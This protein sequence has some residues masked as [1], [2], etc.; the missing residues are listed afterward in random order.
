MDTISAYSK[1]EDNNLKEYIEYVNKIPTLKLKEE[2][3]PFEKYKN[4]DIEARNT[5]INSYLKKVV[6]I[7]KKYDNSRIPLLELIQEGNKTLIDKVN[8]YNFDNT[9]RFYFTFFR[10]VDNSIKY[11]IINNRDI[12]IPYVIALNIVN[13]K[14]IEKELKQ[15]MGRE[16]SFDEINEKLNIDDKTFSIVKNYRNGFKS[17]EEITKDEEYDENKDS[18]I[19]VIEDEEFL[20][21]LFEFL[22][23]QDSYKNILK[24][25][26]MRNG[27]D[28]DKR[29]T[30]REIGNLLNI[31]GQWVN[32]E[33]LKVYKKI[34]EL[35]DK[36]EMNFKIPEK[37]IIEKVPK[38]RKKRE[39]KVNIK[40]KITESQNKMISKFNKSDIYE[41]YNSID[42]EYKYLIENVFLSEETPSINYLTD[43][44]KEIFFAVIYP[45]LKRMISQKEKAKKIKQSDELLEI[46]YYK[47]LNRIKREIEDED[48][49]LTLDFSFK[50]I[51]Y[52][53]E[54]IDLQYKYMLK[55]IYNKSLLAPSISWM[56]EKEREIFKSIVHP[57]MK[58]IIK[59]SKFRRKSKLCKYEENEFLDNNNILYLGLGIDNPCNH[60]L[61]SEEL[62]YI[63]GD[64]S[65]VNF[66]RK[67]QIKK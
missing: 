45:I 33:E 14:K 24:I 51:I 31:T 55:K 43:E 57:Y 38:E 62:A 49:I 46:T 39:S 4:G 29:Y 36:E 65:F 22:E 53:Y 3:E 64:S 50:E 6:T 9:V 5:I 58:K 47:E 42:K 44:E 40:E 13:Y 11:Y 32:H 23:S 25:I 41:L 30:V 8:S 15:K 54:N 1:N 28:C 7:A 48:Y 35:I 21:K 60:K 67:K 52:I 20:K 37:K 27:Y 10:D 16:P 19:D 2:K 17:I 12:K 56:N 18:F 26:K 63:Y 34:N 61:C 66:T 59:D